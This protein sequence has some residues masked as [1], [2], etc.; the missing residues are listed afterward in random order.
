[1]DREFLIGGALRPPMTSR[2]N[3]FEQ[4]LPNGDAQLDAHQKRRD[5]HG[6]SRRRNTSMPGSLPRIAS[7]LGRRTIKLN[8]VVFRALGLFLFPDLPRSEA[9]VAQEDQNKKEAKCQRKKPQS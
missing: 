8:A 9:G 6:M 3:K 7:R 4:T 5:R 2:L 1:M